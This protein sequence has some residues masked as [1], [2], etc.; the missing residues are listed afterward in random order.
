MLLTVGGLLPALAVLA[1]QE[2]GDALVVSKATSAGEPTTEHDLAVVSFEKLFDREVASV[3]TAAFSFEIVN[4]GLSGD[5][6]NWRIFS[7]NTTPDTGDDITIGSGDAL[8]ASGSLSRRGREA[9]RG[10]PPGPTQ[11]TMR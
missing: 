5:T 2:P 8:L 4:Q 7:N 10:T 1:N 9:Y 11:E 3:D 6:A